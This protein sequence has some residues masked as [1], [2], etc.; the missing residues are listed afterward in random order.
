MDFEL[1]AETTQ[2]YY[3]ALQHGAR[4]ARLAL[5]GTQFASQLL[6]LSTENENERLIDIVWIGVHEGPSRRSNPSKSV[7][8][9]FTAI[10]HSGESPRRA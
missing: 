3:T 1:N 9:G 4:Y 7:N 6:L 8:Q 10:L 2:F 5:P